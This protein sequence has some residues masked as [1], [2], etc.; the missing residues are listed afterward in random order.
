M[1]CAGL[2]LSHDDR[3][4]V[5]ENK[6]LRISGHEKAGTVTIGRNKH[7]TAQ[8]LFFTRNYVRGHNLKGRMGRAY[9]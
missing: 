5:S 2:K 1:V 8:F 3:L 9:R 7:G 6:M 4:K